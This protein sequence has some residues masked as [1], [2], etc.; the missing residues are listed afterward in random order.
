MKKINIDIQTSKVKPLGSFSYPP[1][2]FQRKGEVERIKTA[3]LRG[4]MTK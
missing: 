3:S 1:T 4:S 2:P